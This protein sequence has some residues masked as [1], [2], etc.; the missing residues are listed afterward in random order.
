MYVLIIISLN[1]GSMASV[2]GF[3]TMDRCQDQGKEL[4]DSLNKQAP[5]LQ[6]ARICI[7]TI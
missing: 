6:L 3:S 4:I 2:P 5:S 7:K 1:V